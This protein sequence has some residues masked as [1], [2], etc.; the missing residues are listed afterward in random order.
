MLLALISKMQRLFQH[1]HGEV[2]QLRGLKL[3]GLQ[4]L[5]DDETPNDDVILFWLE[6]KT[7][8]LRI[9]IDGTYCGIDQYA[10]DESERDDDDGVSFVKFDKVVSGTT[11]LS[12]LVESQD[13]PLIA[14]TIT[15]SN[16]TRLILDCDADG[17]STLKIVST[18]AHRV[19]SR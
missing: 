14:L 12:A 10:Q 9:F 7:S 2:N 11:I 16:G 13:L 6:T 15:L 8:W 1:D 3:K 19:L 5:F 18:G 4:C 17:K